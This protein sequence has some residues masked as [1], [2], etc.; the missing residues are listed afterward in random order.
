[1]EFWGEPSAPHLDHVQFRPS[2]TAGEEDR[3][4]P[5]ALRYLLV[6][7]LAA[8]LG[9]ILAKGPATTRAHSMTS[10]AVGLSVRFLSVET[11]TG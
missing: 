6:R 1:M 10:F 4:S 2:R 7:G 11:A 8:A 3:R 9:L 5:E